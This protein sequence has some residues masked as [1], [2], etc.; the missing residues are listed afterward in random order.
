VTIEST[1]AKTS[2]HDTGRADVEKSR[3][4]VEA[5]PEAGQ[6]TAQ[7]ESQ[8]AREELQPQQDRP[9]EQ[10]VEAERGVVMPPSVVQ[11]VVPTV[12]TPAPP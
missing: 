9:T 10:A 11:V 5:P 4:V 2:I 6:E 7:P 12:K 8:P 1:E 3:E